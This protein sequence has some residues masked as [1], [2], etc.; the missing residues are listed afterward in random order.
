MGGGGQLPEALLTLASI[1]YVGDPL[2]VRGFQELRGALVKNFPT[3]GLLK[4]RLHEGKYEGF[5]GGY[6]AL[7][8]TLYVPYD[9]MDWSTF[10]LRLASILSSFVTSGPSATEAEVLLDAQANL[11][12]DLDSYVEVTEA[13]RHIGI[14]KY[15]P[16]LSLF[17]VATWSLLVFSPELVGTSTVIYLLSAPA[18]VSIVMTPCVGPRS[19][20]TSRSWA[21]P[22]E[23]LFLFLLLYFSVPADADFAGTSRRWVESHI[24]G[25]R[26][27]YTIA[28]AQLIAVVIGIPA[29]PI[30]WMLRWNLKKRAETLR[31]GDV[32]PS[33]ALRETYK[34][35]AEEEWTVDAAD[36]TQGIV[37]GFCC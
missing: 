27:G 33:A 2:Q 23:L 14:S 18:V 20:F 34:Q 9:Q 28:L 35:T 30:S 11:D 15:G 6:L 1:L 10:L 19:I 24:A 17:S 29:L 7:V 25:I 37:L 8:S 4:H 36:A 21:T 5:V 32:I 13:C 3:P 16:A 22:L 12:L 26:A 31:D